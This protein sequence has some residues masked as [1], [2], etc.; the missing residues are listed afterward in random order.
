MVLIRN[1]LIICFV[2]LCAASLHGQSGRVQIYSESTPLSD[3]RIV[4]S[5]PPTSNSEKIS[6][7]EDDI[8]KVDTD[9]VVIPSQISDR[10]G[11]PV[12]DLKKEEFKIFE[13]GIEQEIAYFNGD[14]QPFTVALVLDMSYSSVFKLAEIQS[15][16]L[17]FIKQLHPDDK[18]L[19]VSFD[20]K[21]RVLC[22]VTDNRKALRLAIEAAKIASGTS[23]YA[24]MDLVLTEKMRNITGRK[25]VVL[26]S[27]GVDTSSAKQTFS[28][29]TRKAAESEVLIYPIQYDTFD[30]VQKSRKESAQ[31]FYDEND[32]PYTI[33]TPRAKGERT[34]D[35]RRAKEFAAQIAESSG[36][37]VY[38]VASAT[39][40]N[41]AFS[42]IAAELRQ[43]YSIGYYPREERKSGARYAINVR[44]YRP[45]LTIRARS[46]YFWKPNQSR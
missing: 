19:I 42:R 41:S 4:V 33:E 10:R 16:A 15:A 21:V 27:D 5:P 34:E 1:F 12:R 36:G 17:A 39:N 28:D 20:E 43:I 29:V 23:L 26:L 13:N 44:V 45:D 8:I 46:G 9:L 2:L 3:K 7:V 35:Y 6:S 25:A 18:V 14:E 32:R 40:L 31:I 37:G 22:E 24:A 11:K 30:D 38:R